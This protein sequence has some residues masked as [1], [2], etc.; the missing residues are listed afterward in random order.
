[1]HALLNVGGGSKKIPIPPRYAGW[2][3]DLLDIDHSAEADVVMDAREL[4]N[5]AAASYDAVYCSHAVEHF[6]PHDVPRV[7]RGFVHVL[8]PDGFAEVRVPNLLTVMK[9]VAARGLDVD[10]PLYYV[11]KAPILV[12]DVIYGY[13]KQIE[14]S[15]ND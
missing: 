11:A 5:L 13:G 6:Y 8:K 14:K 10:D 7:L 2:R 15:G 12:R 4:H 9:F 3:H 1:M